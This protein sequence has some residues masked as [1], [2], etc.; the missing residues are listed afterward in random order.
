MRV[1]SIDVGTNAIRFLAA[2][3]EDDVSY[4]VIDETR[5]PIRMGHS[6]FNGEGI[7][8]GVAEEAAEGLAQFSLRM[9]DLSIT[10]YRA[11]ATSA[12]RESTNRRDFLRRVRTRAGLRLE[13]ISGSEEIRLVHAAVRRRLS[14]GQDPWVMVELGGGS[15][16]IA[17]AN[18]SRVMW[19]ETHAMG[20]VRLLEL[21]ARSAEEPRGFVR[22]V[23]EY[24]ATI[25]LPP[26]LTNGTPTGS[27]R[28]VETSRRSRARN[29]AGKRETVRP[30]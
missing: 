15:V 10:R 27:L 22:L 6:V 17:L 1:A 30:G 2:E 25:R 24:V 26:P 8:A 13:V 29:R 4:R 12:V 7:A 11:V 9:K 28:R 18:D 20:A 23:E 21:F 16:E 5:L 19:C 14:M 3:F